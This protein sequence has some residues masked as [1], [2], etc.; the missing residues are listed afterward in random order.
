[1]VKALM[2]SYSAWVPM[3]FAA[4]TERIFEFAREVVYQ[5]TNGPRRSV[6]VWEPSGVFEAF[7]EVIESEEF[8]DD[9]STCRLSTDGYHRTIFINPHA[10]DYIS[11]P[12]HIY[13]EGQIDANDEAMP[14][15]NDTS[16]D[17][18][19]GKV[20]KLSQTAPSERRRRRRSEGLN[21]AAA[22]AEAA[23]R[24]TPPPPHPAWQRQAD[25]LNLTE[26][27]I[28]RIV[29]ENGDPA[30]VL[31]NLTTCVRGV[32]SKGYLKREADGH[33]ALTPDGVQ[34]RAYLASKNTQL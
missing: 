30:P 25:L 29:A 31:K 24:E 8:D 32:I 28:L 20:V 18:G 10:M 22:K 17:S 12:A 33:L 11:I 14:D 2:R 23:Q 5:I 4:T 27:D 3:N 34:A 19:S 7:W 26:I 16:N 21:A 9:I 6:N 13:D 15:D 1:M